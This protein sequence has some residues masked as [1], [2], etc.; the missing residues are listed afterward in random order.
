MSFHDRE[1]LL[2]RLSEGLKETDKSVVFVLGA[3]AAATYGHLQGVANVEEVV[4]LIRDRF[5]KKGNQLAALDQRLAASDNR[6]QTAFDFLTGRE[7][8]NAANGIVRR[9]VAQALKDGKQ[10]SWA[11]RI[12]NLPA[13]D[14]NTLDGT[15]DTWNIPPALDAIGALIAGFPDRFGN[16]VITSN[17]DPLIEVAIRK[18]G[19][20]AWRTDLATDGSLFQS[21]AGGC[22]VAHIHGYWHSSDTL[23]GSH[24]LLSSRPN[25]ANSLLNILRDSIVVVSAYGGWPDI[26]TSAIRGVVAN[27][28][29]MPDV[30]WTFYENDPKISEYLSRTLDPGL[31]RNRIT[32]YSGVDCQS[33]FPELLSAWQ[34]HSSAALPDNQATGDLKSVNNPGCNRG[35]LLKISDLECDRPPNVEVWVGREAEMRAL[36]T[37]NARVAI[38]CGLGGEGKSALASEYI[39]RL[40]EVEGGYRQWDWR[41]CKEQSDRIRTQIVEVIVRFSAGGISSEDLAKASDSELVEVMVDHIADTHSIIVFDN[42]DSYV[43]LENGLFIGLLDNLVQMMA[44]TTS[45]SRLLITCRPD[46]QYTSTAITT[47]KLR[48]ISETEAIELFA[49]RNSNASVPDD[50]VREAW[51]LTNGHAFWLDLLAVQVNEVPGTTL[52]KQLSDMRRG[53]DNVPDVLSSIWGRLAERERTLLRLMA[54]AMRPETEQTIEKFA[55]SQLGYHRLARRSKP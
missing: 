34:A 17:F 35:K 55:S 21:K 53:S 6:Y 22:Q 36:E 14:L 12:E 9:A 24:Q 31:A 40:E 1:A 49:K 44:A 26:F 11:E 38:I 47:L 30:I 51:A 25:L 4:Q 8:Q 5:S 52:R 50:D 13:H 23:H 15:V 18:H 33:F 19:G 28:D 27:S 54:E 10:A 48:G 20:K 29:L 46:V 42:V 43:D 16:L 39:S 41:D 45:T 2:Y 7:G 32:A 3:P 37:S